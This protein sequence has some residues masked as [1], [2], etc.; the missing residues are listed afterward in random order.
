MLHRA[1]AQSRTR[2]VAIAPAPALTFRAAPH[3]GTE[4][5]L[6]A[7][8]E[9]AGPKARERRANRLEAVIGRLS[10][11]NKFSWGPPR[12]HPR[13]SSSIQHWMSS[14]GVC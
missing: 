6:A 13:F 14:G 7:R 1:P 5:G 11:L 3:R 8:V 4:S 2:H 9:G 12:P 10:N